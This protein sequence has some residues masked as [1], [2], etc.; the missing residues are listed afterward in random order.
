MNDGA[1]HFHTIFD[2]RREYSDKTPIHTKE[3]SPDY[4]YMTDATVVEI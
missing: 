1:M 3:N 4:I 2:I